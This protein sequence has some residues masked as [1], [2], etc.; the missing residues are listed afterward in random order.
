MMHILIAF[1]LDCW[2]HV[3]FLAPAD[4]IRDI[5]DP[6]KPETLEELEVVNESGVQV[7]ALRDASSTFLIHIEFVPTVPHCSLATLIGA[8]HSWAP[9]TSWQIFLHSRLYTISLK[10]IVYASQILVVQHRSYA[11]WPARPLLVAWGK[12]SS[13]FTTKVTQS[14]SSY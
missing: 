2:C 13:C 9:P 8:T 6:E 12:F 14:L 4:L 11:V 5:R 3:R 1:C 7:Q 10:K